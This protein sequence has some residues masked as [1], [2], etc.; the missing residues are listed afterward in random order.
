MHKWGLYK[1][2]IKASFTLNRNRYILMLGNNGLTS[3]HRR[4]RT[5]AC[6]PPKRDASVGNSEE[7]ILI[8]RQESKSL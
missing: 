2:A 6:R 5:A 8:K 7:I 4:R 3:G 1:K